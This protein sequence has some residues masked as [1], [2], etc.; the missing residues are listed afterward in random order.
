MDESA[1]FYT[2]FYDVSKMY[3]FAFYRELCISVSFL[4][5]LFA[6]KGMLNE[7][8]HTSKLDSAL[9]VNVLLY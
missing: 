5:T 1:L 8:M 3:F 4:C 6:I 9:M 2:P 7:V